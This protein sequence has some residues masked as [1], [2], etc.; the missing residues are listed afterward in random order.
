MI[1]Q[2]IALLAAILAIAALA[3]WLEGR[4][5]WAQ[6]AGASLLIIVFGALLSNLDVV[7]ASSPVYAVITGPVTSFAI[8]WLLLMVTAHLT[9]PSVTWVG[10]LAAVTLATWV[11]ATFAA[12]GVAGWMGSALAGMLG[13]TSVARCLRIQ[14]VLIAAGP[15]TAL[16]FLLLALAIAAAYQ[17]AAV[18]IVILALLVLALAWLIVFPFVLFVIIGRSKS[19]LGVRW[20]NIVWAIIPPFMASALML[21]ILMVAG[22]FMVSADI[23][24]SLRLLLMVAI[25]MVVYAGIAWFGLRAQWLEFLD[26]VRR[27]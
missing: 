15:V 6:K 17:P 27:R 2:P 5:G 26:L 1:E 9:D 10:G 20:S 3:F 22:S 21:F 13:V 7:P 4:F 11:C 24:L 23:A 12:A 14:W 8:V 18:M 25:G 19:L 16:G